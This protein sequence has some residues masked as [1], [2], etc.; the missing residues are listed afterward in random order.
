METPTIDIAGAIGEFGTD[1]LGM[2]T[3]AA[4]AILPIIGGM[5]VIYAGIGLF[6]K[7]VKK[8]K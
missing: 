2:A 7:F 3:S 1:I 8:A 4:P 5:A 6:S